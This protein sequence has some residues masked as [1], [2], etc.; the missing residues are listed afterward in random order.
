ME[1]PFVRPWTA[2][3]A[4]DVLALRDS[5]K[6]W[7]QW[8]RLQLS[9]CNVIFGAKC[10]DAVPVDF[11]TSKRSE[12]RD[13]RTNKRVRFQV[14]PHGEYRDDAI[15][16]GVATQREALWMLRDGL[17]MTPAAFAAVAGRWRLTV[18]NSTMTGH[19]S[20]GVPLEVLRDEMPRRHPLLARWRDGSCFVRLP[21]QILAHYC[22]HG[23]N[24][25]VLVESDTVVVTVRLV[26]ASGKVVVMNAP[27]AD[28]A[29]RAVL[30]VPMR[31]LRTIDSY[32]VNLDLD[33]SPQTKK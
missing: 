25:D 19:L 23:N 6:A 9:V 26:A 11:A 16:F 17:G 18:I 20:P 27:S 1:E 14:S 30:F 7:P 8:A 4:P 5:L 12:P 10:Q 3:E 24:N 21:I 13:Q 29:A 33:R 2:E 28:W 15:I 22:C 31:M 32:W